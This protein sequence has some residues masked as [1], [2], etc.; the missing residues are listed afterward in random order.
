MRFDGMSAAVAAVVASAVI[1]DMAP[2]VS[3]TPLLGRRGLV[4]SLGRLRDRA[5]AAPVAARVRVA[6]A[7]DAAR[8]APARRHLAEDHRGQLPELRPLAPRQT[9]ERLLE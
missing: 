2:S 6:Q 8:R 9:N 1:V 7:A 4:G 5:V 3:E